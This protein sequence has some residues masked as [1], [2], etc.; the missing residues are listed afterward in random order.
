MLNAYFRT[1]HAAARRISMRNVFGAR[2][3][4]R[5]DGPGTAENLRT[6]FMFTFFFP[7]VIVYGTYGGRVA[8]SSRRFH[9]FA[10]GTAVNRH[11]DVDTK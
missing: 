8:L 5:N 11:V 1:G 7:S 2:G 10:R 9:F 6:L 3:A 4:V